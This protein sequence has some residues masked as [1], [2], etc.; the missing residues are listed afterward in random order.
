MSLS[1]N[2]LIYIFWNSLDSK[3]KCELIHCIELTVHWC[4]VHV[5]TF[6]IIAAYSERNVLHKVELYFRKLYGIPTQ[7]HY[8]SLCMLELN[9]SNCYFLHSNLFFPTGPNTQFND[10]PINLCSTSICLD[11][12]AL[13]PNDLCSSWSCYLVQVTFLRMVACG[14]PS[15]QRQQPPMTV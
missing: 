6:C 14:D 1:I 2:I 9:I 4:T 10:K 3:T 12:C 15:Q 13:S 7:H 5:Q 8:Y 11:L